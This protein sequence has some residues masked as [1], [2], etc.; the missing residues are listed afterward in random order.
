MRL[1]YLRVT[2]VLL[3]LGVSA[4]VVFG[5]VWTVDDDDAQVTAD[6]STIQAAINAASAGD[7]IEV[8]VG[9]YTE[10]PLVDKQLTLTGI[11][12]TGIKPTI[13]ANNAGHAI[14][15]EADG[16]TVQGFNIL[17]A[18]KLG[19]LDQA[20]F[21][22]GILAGVPHPSL[23]NAY[24]ATGSHTISGNDIHDSGHGIRFFSTGDNNQV[25]CVHSLRQDYILANPAF[26][27]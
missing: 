22:V 5:A 21:Y 3:I 23:P 19:E 16:C 18:N 17:G 25:C 13:F 26:G 24:I 15:L 10:R 8:Y 9:T 14:R 12:D 27:I 1:L 11:P 2:L 6:F 7:T 4:P 20:K